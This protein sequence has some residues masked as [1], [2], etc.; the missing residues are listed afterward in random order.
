M[1]SFDCIVVGAGIHGLC[2]AFWLRQRG[3]RRVA[4]LDQFEPGHTR[5]SSHGAS[6]ITRS[7]YAEPEFVAL[8]TRAHRDEWPALERAIGH[9]LRT[10]TA[11]VFFGPSGGPIDA[12]IAATSAGTDAVE[13]LPPDAARRRF[14]L[15]RFA[16]EDRILL[17]HT[18]AVVHAEATLASLRQWLVEHEVEMRW[19]TRVLQ[20]EESA[21][22]VELTTDRGELLARH[23]VLACG[24]WAPRLAGTG[25]A[26]TVLRQQVGYF[27]LAAPASALRAGAFPVWARIGPGRNEFHY[28][29]PATDQ[30][31]VKAAVHRTAGAD[32]DP[33]S[34]AEPID[35]AALL[36]LARQRFTVTV[37]GLRASEHCLYTMAPDDRLQVARPSQRTVCITACSGHAFKFGPVLGHQAA[38]LVAEATS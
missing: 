35:T 24:A 16:P 37:H 21:D 3:V 12:Y 4:V 14:P 6:R 8:A 5:G 20:R 17:D 1:N 10:P 22:R 29:L 7:S 25:T 28:G 33:D 9:S 18:A 19:Q 31:G 38:D 27:E 23:V 34:P 13:C 2:T 26:T 15:L 30:R 11:G 32:T 36:D